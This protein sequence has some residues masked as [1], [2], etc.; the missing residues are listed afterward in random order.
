MPKII[1]LALLVLFILWLGSK[2]TE[3]EVAAVANAVGLPQLPVSMNLESYR[4]KDDQKLVEVN[5]LL[6]ADFQDHQVSYV[7]LNRLPNYLRYAFIAT[8]DSRFFQHGPVD[9][10]GILRATVTNLQNQQIAE[11]GSTITQQLAKN[12]F[13]SQERTMM[14]KLEE[15]YLAY[16]LEKKY[17]KTQILEMYLNQ[18]YFGGGMYG[19]DRA[20]HKIFGVS[21]EEVTLAQ[22]AML[23]GIPKHPSKYW[24][25]EH[26]EAATER[27]R[28]V[29]DRM[30]S[31]GY[32]TRD[33]AET[34]KQQV[35]LSKE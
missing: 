16:Q 8:E 2:L 1:K 35:I 21:A 14:R 32:I 22:A 9:V 6:I 29:L 17:S 34:A 19:V 7:P 20:A 27:Q 10:K 12:L 33:E 4:G 31:I 18:I 11:G 26:P 15:V 24:P 13:L 3:V 30:V 28:I 23:A 25:L 5:G